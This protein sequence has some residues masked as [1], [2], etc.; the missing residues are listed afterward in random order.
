MRQ[1]PSFLK[2]SFITYVRPII[3]PFLE[4][5]SPVFTFY[6]SSVSCALSSDSFT[7]EIEFFDVTKS[8]NEVIGGSDVK[9]PHPFTFPL[10]QVDTSSGSQ[11][12]ECTNGKLVI[13][14]K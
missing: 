3:I 12:S 5:I 14:E 4:K 2:V 10:K 8:T 11:V 6:K 13:V 7:P 1:T 9:C